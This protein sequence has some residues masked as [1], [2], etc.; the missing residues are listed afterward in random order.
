M[1]EI[2][3]KCRV[4]TGNKLKVIALITMII[5]HIGFCLVYRLMVCHVQLPF[6]CTEEQLME[7]YNLCRKIGRIAFPIY[8]FLLVEGFKYTSNIWK[9]IGRMTILALISEPVFNLACGARLKSAYHQNTFWTLCLGLVMLYCMSLCEN[10][11]NA[12]Q[13]QESKVNKKQAKKG[14]KVIYY[15][16]FW[17]IVIELIL[18]CVFAYISNLLNTDYKIWGIVWIALFYLCDKYLKYPLMGCLGGF[19]GMVCR[20][21]KDTFERPALIAFIPI[22]LYNGKRGSKNK[23]LSCL[24]YVAYPLHLAILYLLMCYF[25]VNRAIIW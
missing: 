4:L 3:N 10:Q 17:Y 18:P 9:Y 13:S 15:S 25:G 6:A 8:C 12:I 20:V 14:K 22:A 7:V 19:I 24:F 11:Y 21:V 5:D 23:V 2:L 16:K 1:V